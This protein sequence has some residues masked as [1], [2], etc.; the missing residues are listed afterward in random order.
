M[1]KGKQAS[2]PAARLSVREFAR[3]DKTIDQP[4]DEAHCAQI[5]L[6]QLGN[7]GTLNLNGG[8]L[9][10]ANIN[11][12]TGTGQSGL[13]TSTLNFNGGTLKAT[14]DNANY[15]SGNVD[16][17]VIYPGGATIA[18]SERTAAMNREKTCG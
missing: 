7:V 16:G 4:D 2:G 12:G 13:G 3:V 1:P 15:M 14:T 9:T 6:D 18:K 10:T 5:H 8:T 17:I 11:G